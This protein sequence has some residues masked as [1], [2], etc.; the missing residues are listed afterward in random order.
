M[1]QVENQHLTWLIDGCNLPAAQKQEILLWVFRFV[2]DYIA[3]RGIAGRERPIH[4]F[5]D[6]I[7]SILGFSSLQNEAVAED[8][9]QLITGH[10]RNFGCVLTIAHQSLMQINSERIRAAMMGMPNQIFGRISSPDDRLYLAKKFFQYEPLKSK[11]MIPQYVNMAEP[12]IIYAGL[13]PQIF[14]RPNYV[15]LDYVNQPY[16]IDEQVQQLSERFLNL[17]RFW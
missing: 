6:E 7:T 1:E 3:H 2:T 17:D 4:F 5:I 16:S 8:L 11:Q 10:A 9:E 13:H 15:A 14:A 12:E